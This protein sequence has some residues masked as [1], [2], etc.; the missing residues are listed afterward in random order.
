M[1]KIYV[2]RPNKNISDLLKEMIES[3]TEGIETIF[4][5]DICSIPDLKNKKLLFAIELTDIGYDI[6][7]I[8]FFHKL[9]TKEPD[10]LKGSVGA[11]LTH[12]ITEFSTKRATQDLI[13]MANNLGCSFIGHPLV[14]AT[15]SL[16]NF[17]TWQK[18]INLPLKELCLKMCSR[19]GN[20]LFDY[21]YNPVKNPRIL[22]LYSSPHTRSNTLDLWHLVSKHLDNYCIKELE[23][24]NGEIMDC[25][26][27]PYN[28]CVHYGKQ[29]SCF[30]GGI[31]VREVLPS[32]EEADV[33]VWLC[34]NYNDSIAANLTA[35]IN[36]LTV[37]YR[38]ISFYNKTIFSVIV[39][40]NSGSDS[41][42]KQLIGS[43][44][45]NK[46]FRLP[47]HFAITAIANDPYAIFEIDNIEKRTC[48]FSQNFINSI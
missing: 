34:P 4:I 25:K 26:G 46:G 10:A 29:K 11:V 6:P 3:A 48:K 28:L 45:I 13:F 39:S 19:L 44:N 24:E 18:T 9:Y 33:I 17:A 15:S 43:L 23:I 16:R 5:D 27:C 31:M 32:I 42:A 1:N 14:E 47:P 35:A 21:Y 41:V 38:T 20:R 30:Y 37:L 8:Q 36:R 40:G 12:S 22:V 2:I 7:M